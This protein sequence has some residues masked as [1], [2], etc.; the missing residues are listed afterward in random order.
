MVCTGFTLLQDEQDGL[1]IDVGLI[2]AGF[3]IYNPPVKVR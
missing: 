3:R 2:I 1:S